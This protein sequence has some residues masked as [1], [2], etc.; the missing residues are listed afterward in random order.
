MFGI[1]REM[2]LSNELRLSG[3]KDNLETRLLLLRRRLRRRLL[4]PTA[5]NGSRKAQAGNSRTGASRITVRSRV[6]RTAVVGF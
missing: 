5:E 3:F 6:G 2:R 1:N 4:H